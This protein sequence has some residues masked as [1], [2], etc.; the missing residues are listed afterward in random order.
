MNLLATLSLRIS[1]NFR[2]MLTKYSEHS[3]SVY[4]ALVT[5]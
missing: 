1:Q 3:S 4:G 2:K 5:T